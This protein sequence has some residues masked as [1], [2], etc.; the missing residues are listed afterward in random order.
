MATYHTE[1]VTITCRRWIVPTGDRGAPADEVSKAWAAAAAGYRAACGLP[2]DANV[3][4][5]LIIRSTD[6]AVIIEW[7]IEQPA[8]GDD[9]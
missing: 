7:T 6:D 9:V 1:T 5:A 3:T 4:P 8:G 2:D